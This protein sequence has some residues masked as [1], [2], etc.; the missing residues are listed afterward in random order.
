MDKDKLH[1]A[2][3]HIAAGADKMAQAANI[4]AHG[5]KNDDSP[6][7]IARHLS[8]YGLLAEDLPE[9]SRGMG[10][11]GAVWYLPGPIGDIRRMREHIVAF[12]HDCQDKPFRLVLNE[13]EADT[14]ARTLLAA[15][16]YQ[17]QA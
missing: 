4:I 17:E 5:M 2:L 7:R 3:S 8:D 10:T 1:R 13:A 15:A 11:S 9:P 6:A 16:K 14:I 12:G